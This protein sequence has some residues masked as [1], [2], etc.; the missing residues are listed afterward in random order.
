V[1]NPF[2]AIDLVRLKNEL[3]QV[4]IAWATR[5]KTRVQIYPPRRE[6]QFYVRTFVF[7]ESWKISPTYFIGGGDMATDV[8]VDGAEFP[9]AKFVVG[10]EIGNWQNQMYHAGR[11]YLFRKI[12]EDSEAQ[13]VAEAQAVINREL[14]PATITP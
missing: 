2:A 3:A 7:Q 14:A 9:A 13:L 12:I 1:S 6:G 5:I 10:D 8:Y 11:W 4:Q